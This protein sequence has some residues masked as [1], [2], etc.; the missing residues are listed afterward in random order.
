[1]GA[2]RLIAGRRHQ[3]FW[4]LCQRHK[5]KRIPMRAGFVRKSIKGW[6]RNKTKHVWKKLNMFYWADIQLNDLL[7]AAGSSRMLSPLLLP[8]PPL[9]YHAVLISTL[10]SVKPAPDPFTTPLLVHYRTP[11]TNQMIIR[12]TLCKR[13][14]TSK[15]LLCLVRPPSPFP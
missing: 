6:K 5:D 12:A 7:N 10:R 2:G 11:R 13:L 15:P 9:M 1:M 14:E 8:S 4:T 3:F